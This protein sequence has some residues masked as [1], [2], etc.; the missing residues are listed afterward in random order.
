[1]LSLVIAILVNLTVGTTT[2]QPTQTPNTGNNTETKGNDK[3][4]AA[5]PTLSTMG[6]VGHWTE[7]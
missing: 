7:G 4:K 5:D 3:S 6:G 1:M 2:S